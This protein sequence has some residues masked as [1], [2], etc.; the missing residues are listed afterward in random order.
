MAEIARLRG[1]SCLSKIY[2]NNRVKLK[3][4]CDCGYVFENNAMHVKN[5]GQWCSR[6]AGV[7]RLTMDDIHALALKRNIQ[8]L[9]TTYINN[10][11]KMLWKCSVGHEWSAISNSITNGRGCPDCAKGISERICRGWFTY[12]FNKKFP[13]VKPAWLSFQ[14]SRFELDGYCKELNLA[15]EYQGYQH[16]EQSRVYHKARSL[17]K[18][19]EVDALKKEIC[20]THGVD[21][22][23]VPYLVS[24]TEMGQFIVD[25]C[26]KLGIYVPNPNLLHADYFS[27]GAFA[28]N[29]FQELQD[30]CAKRAIVCLSE[31][32]LGGHV[33]HQF[34]CVVCHHEWETTPSAIKAGSGCLKCSWRRHTKTM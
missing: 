4:K 25:E 8:C 30:V 34:S 3:W 11:T 10:R 31:A 5:R 19:V 28:S 24:Y 26:D 22:I 16:F 2:S 29:K 32:Y 15:F 14:N 13:R 18:Q 23:A 27:F 20:N 33:K 1:G 12:L 6:C 17:Q 9:S 7:K 21:L